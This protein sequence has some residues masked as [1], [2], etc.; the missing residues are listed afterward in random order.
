MKIRN[1]IL[2]IIL[3]FSSCQKAEKTNDPLF[4]LLSE[5]QTGVSFRNDLAYSEKINPYTFRNFYNG[6]G[7]ALGD[8]NN[9]GL[10]DILFAGN[11]T[12]NRLYLNQGNL[13]FKD[14]T[15][16]AGLESTGYWST[17]V[18]MADINGD[19]LLDIYVS[20][21]GPKGGEKRHNE[22]FI[23]QG[24]LTFSERSKEYGLAEEKLSQH[25]V[26]LDFDKDG[27]LDLYLLANSGRSVGIFDLRE[28]QRELRDPDGGNKLFRNDGAIFT[29]VSESAGI[30]GSA[31]GYGLG[32]TVADLNQDNWPDLYVSN[33]FFERD[34]LYLN[35][36]DGSFSE[37]LT[38]TLNEISMGSMGADIADLDN[39]MRPDI[40]VTEMLPADLAR[41]KTKTPF[42]EWDKYQANVKAGYHNQ[43]TRNTLQRN[44]GFKPGTKKPV[45]I[46]MSRQIGMDATD[47]SWGAL[48]FDADNDGW[49]DVFVAN[50]IVKDLTD[51]DFVDFYVNDQR[52]VQGYREDSV[53][54]TKMI[55][56]FPSIPQQNFWFK[57]LG[58]WEFENQAA[59][60]GL[61]QFTFSTGSA[62]GDLDNDGDL[63]LVVNNL[64]ERAFIYKNKSRENGSGNYLQLD[65][66]DAYGAQVTCFAS[67]KTF[68]QE[69]Q[70]VKGYMSSVDPRLH[71]GLGE[72]TKLDSV[73]ILWPD[74]KTSILKN[75]SANQILKPHQADAVLLDEPLPSI[76]T[77]LSLSDKEIPF[78][79]IESE[80]VDFDRDRLRFWMISNEGPKA[81]KADVNQDGLEDLFIPGAKGKSSTLLIQEKGGKFRNHQS[82]L[83]AVDSLAEDL[84][85]YFFDANGDGAPDLLVGSGSIEFGSNSPLYQDRLYLNDGKGNYDKS[86]Q[87]FSSFPTSFILSN[88]IDQDGD[89]DLIIGTRSIPFAYGI[90]TGIQVWEND[91]KGNFL[92]IS[93]KFG[94][95][96]QSLGMLTAGAIAD[97]DGDGKQELILAGEWMSI[98]IFTFSMDEFIEKTSEFGLTETRGLWNCLL[99][100]DINADGKPDILAGNWGLNSRLKSSEKSKLR[101][102]INDFDQNG[103]L[104]HI[105]VSF[106]G[107]KSN[108]WVMKNNLIKQIPSLR[109]Q[110]LTYSSY[111]NKTLEELFPESVISKSLTLQTDLL[112]TSLWINEGNG[113]LSLSQLPNEIQASPV[114]AIYA[115]PSESGNATLFFGG[116]QSRIKPELG[117]QMGS[118]GWVLKPSGKNQWKSLLPEQSGLFVPGEI[119]SILSIK[120]ENEPHIITLRNNEKPIAFK[121]Q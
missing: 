93:S 68:Y 56:A 13:K 28:G 12:S 91:G 53:L 14:I 58:N 49:K 73:E 40:F 57:N 27:D 35:N 26:F 17:G 4:E 31:I 60:Q 43:F 72:N 94:E 88:D 106:D 115:L 90:P 81:A 48:I 25:A 107:T 41:V 55:D 61:D 114:F 84:T 102:V 97:L 45:F 99:V 21:S 71:F 9:D 89:E 117:G 3:L 38:E 10:I 37:V 100:E 74:G 118:Y 92:N 75:V 111:Q 44:L 50:G 5:E 70:P 79:H 66:G 104:D 46:E 82:T 87:V 29:D 103:S 76:T 63:D 39:D 105:L 86:N 54:L 22:L 32:V 47:W 11:Q 110:L 85:A 96:I 108:P 65:L 7:V 20:K 24:D 8:I 80:F 77:L 112:E 113:K 109:K 42:E 34:Y 36:Q 23:N 51:F 116:N 120:I 18:S 98:R 52:K 15:Q 69:F 16:S 95:A 121:L 33:D 30:Y 2:P 67:E 83:F 64:N 1:Y 19:G 119:R 59:T 6:A 78:K 62:Y 101:M